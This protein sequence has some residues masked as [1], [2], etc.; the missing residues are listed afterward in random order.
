MSVILSLFLKNGSVCVNIQETILDSLSLM[1]HSENYT[2]FI[3]ALSAVQTIMY[4]D[5]KVF[6]SPVFEVF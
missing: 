2:E 6:M 3:L 4:Q 5:K 1:V